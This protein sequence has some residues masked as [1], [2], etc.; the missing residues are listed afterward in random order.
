[1]IIPTKNESADLLTYLS[2]LEKLPEKVYI[3]NSDSTDNRKYFGDRLFN[4]PLPHFH[5]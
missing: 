1:M 4:Q 3:V 2:S 5:A